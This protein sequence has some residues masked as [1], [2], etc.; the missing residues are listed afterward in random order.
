MSGKSK[1]FRWIHALLSSGTLA[2]VVLAVG[3]PGGSQPPIEED[4]IFPANFRDLFTIVR[5]CRNSIEHGATIRVWVNDIG[6]EGYLA[7]ASPLPE[8]TIVIKEEFFGGGCDNDE[9]LAF[10]SVMRKEAA[11]F[12]PAGNDWRFQEVESPARRIALDNNATC[13]ACHT[14]EE[15]IPRD[16]MCTLP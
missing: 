13:L 8:G 6:V 14:A 12:D 5:D 11:G 4:I 3:C 9:D 16:L 2:M 10:W 1:P 15:C 7:D